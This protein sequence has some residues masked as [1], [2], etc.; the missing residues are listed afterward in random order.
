MNA[1]FLAMRPLPYHDHYG[2]FRYLSHLRCELARI[3]RDE[4]SLHEPH[5]RAM[6]DLETWL[7]LP[8]SEGLKAVQ[9]YRALDFVPLCQAGIKGGF[10]KEPK[11]STYMYVTDKGNLSVR[12]FPGHMTPAGRHEKAPEWRQEP[13]DRV[14]PDRRPENELLFVRGFDSLTPRRY[15]TQ[16]FRCAT[17]ILL[18]E[19]VEATVDMLI[20]RLDQ[21]FDVQVISEFK[22]ETVPFVTV[23]GTVDGRIPIDWQ[24]V[25][26]VEEERNVLQAFIDGFEAAQGMTIAAFLDLVED[27][28]YQEAYGRRST[29]KISNELRRRG[30]K[31]LPEK[32]MWNLINKIAAAQRADVWS[33]PEI[34]AAA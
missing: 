25:N 34:L 4:W 30:L 18:L 6:Q 11:I 21:N 2:P 28:K 7:D 26:T 3:G 14:Y 17:A 20:K 5:H 32:D 15:S 1:P 29:R 13:G 24:I 9:D 22:L 10:M 12:W 31:G 8:M 27:P 19:A 33:R 16:A 23:D